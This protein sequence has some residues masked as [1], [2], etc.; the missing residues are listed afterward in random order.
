MQTTPNG[1]SD[2][3]L[4]K[5]KRISIGGV[6]PYDGSVNLQKLLSAMKAVSELVDRSVNELDQHKVMIEARLVML[7]GFWESLT[8]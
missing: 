5:A 4:K 8:I 1:L 2:T 6:V 7:E 3:N